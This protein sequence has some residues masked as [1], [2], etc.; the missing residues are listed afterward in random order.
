VADEP[1]TD[2]DPHDDLSISNDTRLLRVVLADQAPEVGDN[3]GLRRASSQGFCTQPDSSRNIIAM[4]VYIEAILQDLGVDPRRLV[5]ELWPGRALAVFE[6]GAARGCTPPLII[7][8]DP[9]PWDPIF[10]PAHAHVCR[11]RGD[12]KRTFAGSQA[13]AMARSSTVLFHPG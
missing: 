11:Q 12:D 1:S 5:T 3:S 2:V 9:M 13:K 4:S 7:A 6:A 10:G 8:K